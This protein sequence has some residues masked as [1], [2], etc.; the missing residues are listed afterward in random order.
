MLLLHLQPELCSEPGAG[1]R[2]KTNRLRISAKFCILY[3]QHTG[4][5][6]FQ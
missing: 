2:P 3:L 6:H 4:S 5:F 1:A